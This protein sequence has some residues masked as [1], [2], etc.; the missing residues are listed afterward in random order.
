M[1]KMSKFRFMGQLYGSMNMGLI[2]PMFIFSNFTIPTKLLA[3]VTIKKSNFI[4]QWSGIEPHENAWKCI[5]S[6]SD[7]RYM[8]AAILFM[9]CT[10]ISILRMLEEMLLFFPKYEINKSH[11]RQIVLFCLEIHQIWIFKKIAFHAFP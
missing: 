5:F 2:R 8:A 7:H 1:S 6:K 4:S 3:Q 10:A 9:N 11:R